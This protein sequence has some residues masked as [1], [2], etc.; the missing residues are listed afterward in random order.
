[1]A[2]D[3]ARRLCLTFDNLGQARRVFEGQASLPDESAPEV[4]V[5][6]P[7]ILGLLSDLGLSTTFFVEGWSAFHFPMVLETIQEAG[8]EVGLHGWIHEKFSDLTRARALQYINDGTTALRRAGVAP[9]GFRAPGGARG[10]FAA[11]ILKQLGYVYDS[12]VENE[13]CE[14]G[15]IDDDDYG[16][17]GLNELP[18]GLINIPW[19]WSMVDA[20]HY[21]LSGSGF[22][23]PA[24][25][26]DYWRSVIANIPDGGL[27]TIIAHAHVSGLDRD[28]LAALR[29]VL[30]FAQ[31]TGVEIV[32]A[33]AAAHAFHPATDKAGEKA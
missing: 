23:E 19:R 13:F 16:G 1:M 14:T 12:S 5:A 18:N 11:D 10:P 15:S 26:A 27:L 32:A 22:R 24:R 33:H 3:D 2:M 30:V 21:L 9:A 20:I 25:L 28:K 8:H 4:S 17:D 31:E 29:D 6:Y 7:N